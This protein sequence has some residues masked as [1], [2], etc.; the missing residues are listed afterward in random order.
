ME[1][2]VLLLVYNRPKQTEV[3]LSRLQQCGI[4]NIFIS[5]D[6]PKNAADKKLTEDVRSVLNS[7]DHVIN[8]TRF[9]EKNLGC[10]NGV[11]SGINWFFEHVDE[12]IILEDDCLPSVHF[13]SFINDMMNRYRNEPKVM[14][15][16]GNNPMGEWRTE[17]GHFF[18]RLG[19]IWGWATWKDR[20]QDFNPQL[21][22][23]N[24]FVANRGFERAFGPTE[25]AA[26]RLDLTR[27]SLGGEI[28]TWD[29]QWNAHILMNQGLAVIP[30][31]NLVEN[32][33]FSSQGTNVHSKP[34]WIKND[35]AGEPNKIISR[36]IQMDREYEMEWNLARRSDLSANPSSFHFEELG[37]TQNRKLKALLI[38][39][40]DEGGGAEKIVFTL[41]Q[42][43]LELGHESRLLVQVKKSKLGSVHELNDWKT[44]I[45]ESGPDVI[46]IHN[47]HG[48]SIS[49]NEF[50]NFVRKIPVLYTL[51]DSWLATGNTDHPFEPDRLKLNLLELKTWKKGFKQRRENLQNGKF[52]YTAPSQW[53]RELFFKAHGIRPFYVP[54]AVELTGSVESETPSS[55]FILFVANRPETNPYKDF[56]TLK[57][58]WKKVNEKLGENACD[59]IVLGGGTNAEKVGNR[60]IFVLEKQSR[61]Q[62]MGF[63]EKSILVV[64]A[65]WQDNAPLAILEAH[66]MGK[67]V[68]G[69]LVGGIPEMLDDRER[70]WLYE[71]GNVGELTAKLVEAIEFALR[72]RE[73][74][75]RETKALENMTATYLGHYFDL[76]MR[77]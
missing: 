54:N 23:F 27:R 22:E 59:L 63:I 15:I 38:N 60:C 43:L 71:A 5:A 33:G 30:E 2:P 51:H 55:R 8:N 46:H 18:S 31:R 16:G 58:A 41:H 35:V 56:S 40:T 26:S 62:V 74:R 75:D 6:G 4:S 69:S 19:T 10:K 1:T 50:T 32:I 70:T 14:M 13:F 76:T 45:N 77:P 66:A 20:W 64:Q 24:E 67:N 39:S 9:S 44:Q 61:E 52:R 7:F 53:M 29:Y 57:K 34:N 65:S 73:I 42:K 48:T 47:L 37:K 17:G 25:L 36:P 28:H 49:L 12:G 11:I 72:D 68:I 3:V 21:P